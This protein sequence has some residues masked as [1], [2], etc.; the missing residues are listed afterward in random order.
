M[1]LKINSIDSFRRVDDLNRMIP[2]KA[3]V[4]Y[5]RGGA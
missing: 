5:Q 4:L 2:Q 3:R 1:G